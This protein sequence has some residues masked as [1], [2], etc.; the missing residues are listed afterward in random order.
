M[1]KAFRASLEDLAAE[2]DWRIDRF[3]HALD[4]VR[5]ALKRQPFL[6]GE[7]PAY[8]DYIV[9]SPLQWA[10]CLSPSDVLRQGDAL[11]D[12]RVRMLD[13]H[14]GLARSMPDAAT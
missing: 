8:V 5:A 7:R 2:R 12:W 3:Q 10:R 9:F 6:G 1:E 11:D 13:L 4:P 14:N